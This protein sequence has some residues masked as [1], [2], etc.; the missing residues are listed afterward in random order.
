MEGDVEGGREEMEGLRALTKSSCGAGG[1]EGPVRF[2]NGSG[3]TDLSAATRG[4]AETVHVRLL[5]RR[6]NTQSLHC[7]VR[8]FVRSHFIIHAYK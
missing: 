2:L 3:K 8:F 1:G 7:P 4:S 5:G 6:R